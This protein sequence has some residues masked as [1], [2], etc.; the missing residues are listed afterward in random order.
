MK[1]ML[2]V[3]II[4][5]VSI[6]LISVAAFSL[7]HFVLND[8]GSSNNEAAIEETKPLTAEE[9]K[10]LTVEVNDI[11]TNLSELNYIVKVNM[12][13]I[14]DSEEAKNELTL[15]TSTVKSIM[16]K[17]LADTA[18]D[19][20]KGSK[21]QDTFTAKIMNAVNA[22]LQEGKLVQVQITDLVINRQ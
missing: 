8:S 12:D 10:E 7:Y 5:L 2:P 17:T 1:K 22:E 4:V 14:V 21:G 6:T 20:M 3:L 9:K 13:F 16:V 19:E 15:L 18:P 11:I